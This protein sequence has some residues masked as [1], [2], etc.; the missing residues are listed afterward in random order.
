MAITVL[1]LTLTT[2]SF[3]ALERSAVSYLESLR[4][5]MVL[6]NLLKPLLGHHV[7]TSSP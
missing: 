5:H 3:V 1:D 2:N 6:A 7:A 4:R